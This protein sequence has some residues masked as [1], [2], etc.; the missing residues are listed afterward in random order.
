MHSQKF[1]IHL[2]EKSSGDPVTITQ[3]HAAWFL[4]FFRNFRHM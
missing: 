4:S 3:G 2:F 1:D